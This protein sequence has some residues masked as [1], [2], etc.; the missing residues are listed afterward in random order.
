MRGNLQVIR[1][2]GAVRLTF[3]SALAC[4]RMAELLTGVAGLMPALLE[5]GHKTLTVEEPA[6][7]P[8]AADAPALWEGLE[9]WLSAWAETPLGRNAVLSGLSPEHFRALPNGSLLYA[10]LLDWRLG[11]P[12]ENIGELLASLPEGHPA[13]KKL[14]T[15]GRERFGA[16]EA[17]LRQAAQRARA[18]RQVESARQEKAKDITA[19]LLA[20]GKSS[21]MGQP[22]HL[23]MLDGFPF[24]EHALYAMERYPHVAVSVAEE[25]PE[26]SGLPQWLDERK[27]LGPL[28][29]LETVLRR[30]QTSAVLVSPCD[31][32][33][34]TGAFLDLLLDRWREDVDCVVIREEKGLNPLMGLYRRSLLPAVSAALDRG[35][36]RAASVLKGARMEAV[37]V[38]EHLRQGTWN[39]NT[40]EEYARALDG[41]EP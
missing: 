14:L 3:R 40:P 13:A 20:G 28:A 29:A 38:P 33:F 11:E 25:R 39:L 18:A 36:R 21:R 4:S 1:E 5:Q 8:L 17:V 37:T 15:M 26:F 10:E 30:A 23:L 31:A 35:E 16:E 24:W 41:R 22:K 9:R 32:P 19:V 2:D 27:G 12:W 7:A 34:V 6:G